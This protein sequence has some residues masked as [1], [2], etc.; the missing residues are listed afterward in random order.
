M[1]IAGD[2]RAFFDFWLDDMFPGPY[3]GK[4][5]VQRARVAG[6][7]DFIVMPYDHSFMMQETEVI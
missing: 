5:S 6:M 1:L 3:D 7:R 2:K 4:V